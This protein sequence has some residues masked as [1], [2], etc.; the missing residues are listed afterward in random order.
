MVINHN[1]SCSV[2][3]RVIFV[4]WV[5]RTSRRVAEEFDYF[6]IVCLFSASL[7]LS[8]YIYR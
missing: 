8:S 4:L 1:A 3:A 7:A 6:K 5:V 2:L